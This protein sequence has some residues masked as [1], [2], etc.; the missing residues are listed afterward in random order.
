VQYEELNKNWDRSGYLIGTAAV[1]KSNWEDNE[2]WMR[3]VAVV[4]QW[5]R[6]GIAS[7]LVSQVLTFCQKSG[8]Y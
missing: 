7:A 2:A 8:I 5:Q 3:R 6:R 1:A 4:P